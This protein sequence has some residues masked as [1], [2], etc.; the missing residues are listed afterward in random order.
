M[1]QLDKKS[2][3]KLYS[4]TAGST[5]DRDGGAGLPQGHRDAA[6]AGDQADGTAGLALEQVVASV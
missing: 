3:P 4:W 5:E 2:N 1:G 6:F